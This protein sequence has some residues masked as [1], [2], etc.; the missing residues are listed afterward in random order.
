MFY[1]ELSME[2]AASDNLV[3]PIISDYR[4]EK[5]F[6]INELSKYEVES[7]VKLHPAI[8]SEIFYPRFINN[9]YFD[10]FNLNNYYD[11]IE[12]TAERMKVR[13][14]WYG[15][16][17][18]YV[19]K[20]ILEKKIK[21]GFLGKKITIP[22]KS[23][24][25][26]ENTKTSDLLQSSN[27]LKETFAVYFDSLK[28]SLLNRYLRKYYESCDGNYRITVDTEQSFYLVNSHGNFFLN[29]IADN[30][31]VILE[32]KYNHDYDS[33]ASYI[34]TKFP[35]RLTKSSKYVTGVE[36]VFKIPS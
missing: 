9:I 28:P 21:K 5:K 14:R 12:G 29:K 32:L 27:D 4:Y 11:N 16:L 20:P 30:N 23:F 7:I 22:I 18:G 17:F 2:K 15:D 8:F 35:F 34:T 24:E 13:I 3:H 26:K 36:R 6:L 19:E 33:G 1:T 10:S 25:L 31:T